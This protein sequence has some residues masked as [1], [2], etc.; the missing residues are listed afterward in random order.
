MKRLWHA[1]L[2]V[3]LVAGELPSV[4]LNTLDAEIGDT[5]TLDQASEFSMFPS[6]RGGCQHAR[7]RHLSRFPQLES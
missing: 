2:L 1:C 3:A 4:A 5:K 6:Q 7:R